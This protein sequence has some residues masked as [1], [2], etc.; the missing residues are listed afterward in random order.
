M[1][2]L[3]TPISVNYQAFGHRTST[4]ILK[5]SFTN[6]SVTVTFIVCQVYPK[7]S[8]PLSPSVSFVRFDC[9]MNFA[10]KFID[11]TITN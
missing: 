7:N 4:E 6:C 10:S 11:K 2:K 1:K 8:A 9:K 3:Q 5:N